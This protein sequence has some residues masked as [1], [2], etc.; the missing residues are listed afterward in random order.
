MKRVKHLCPAQLNI[1]ARKVWVFAGDR[2]RAAEQKGGADEGSEYVG[3]YALRVIKRIPKGQMVLGIHFLPNKLL[4]S[5]ISGYSVPSVPVTE[6]G[7]VNSSPVHGRV[8][9]TSQKRI[10]FI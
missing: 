2:N 9:K 4:H 10:L 8:E 7:N 3:A 6:H 5:I 1:R